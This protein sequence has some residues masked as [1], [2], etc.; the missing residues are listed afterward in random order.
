MVEHDIQVPGYRA[1]LV[2][3]DGRKVDLDDETSRS[4]LL[5]KDSSLLVK[6]YGRGVPR[7][8][9]SQGRRISVGLIG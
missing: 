5:G 8:G 3:P 1:V 2:L 7:I 6:A 4:H 9:N